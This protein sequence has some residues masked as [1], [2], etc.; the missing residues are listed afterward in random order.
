MKKRLKN[1]KKFKIKYYNKRYNFQFY[2][3]KNRSLLNFENIVFDKFS[4]KLNFKF[5]K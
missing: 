5:Y 2:K 4:K 3:V 1:A